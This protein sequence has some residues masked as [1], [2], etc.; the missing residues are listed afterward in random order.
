ML[1]C[2]YDRKIVDRYMMI[3]IRGQVDAQF[4]ALVEHESMVQGAARVETV[5]DRL[6]RNV[7]RNICRYESGYGDR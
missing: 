5:G 3:M 1:I 4:D 6:I 2:R 7:N